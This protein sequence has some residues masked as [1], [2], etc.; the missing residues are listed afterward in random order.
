MVYD[1]LRLNAYIHS[2]QLPVP[3]KAGRLAIRIEP[4]VAAARGGN[5]TKER[6]ESSV[7]V[8]GL[9]SLA[10]E[11]MAL[12]IA[13]DEREEPSQA[14]IIADEPFGARGGH[15]TRRPGVA[16]AGEASGREAPGAVRQARSSHGQ[17]SDVNEDVLAGAERLPLKQVPGDRE[18]YELHSFRHE[19]EPGEFV[20]VR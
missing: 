5:E 16:P 10:V 19:A 6:L 20:Y 1:K 18:H 14:L 2:E 11:Q 9:Y 13:K 8:P 12:Q 4:G 17:R 7:A 3:D 15:G